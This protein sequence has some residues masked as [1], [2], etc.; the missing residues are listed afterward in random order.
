MVPREFT[1]FEDVP[2]P[3]PE[4]A[5]D[6]AA[7]RSITWT[8]GQLINIDTEDGLEE[9]ATILG[10]SSEGDDTQMQV[11]FAD[12]SVENWD[13]EDF[14]GAT[15]A[16]TAAA[17]GADQATLSEATVLILEAAAKFLFTDELQGSLAAF[18]SNYAAMF[19]GASGVQGEQKLEWS[20]AHADFQQLFEFQLERFVEQQPFEVSDFLAACQEALDHGTWANCRGLVQTV[21]SMTSYE[22]FVRMMTAAAADAQAVGATAREGSAHG[23]PGYTRD[24]MSLALDMD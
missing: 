15:E 8:V 9:G 6:Q 11:R 20:E 17:A 14:V 5:A 3:A 22:Y 4:P 13:I 1:G 7:L 24:M 10:P 21:L 19:A 12:G 18:S 2:R 23:A 16:S